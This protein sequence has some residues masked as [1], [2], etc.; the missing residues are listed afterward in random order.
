MGGSDPDFACRGRRRGLPKINSLADFAG[1]DFE[2]K[3]VEDRSNASCSHRATLAGAL[4]Q[5][6]A[7]VHLC[8]VAQRCN[9]KWRKS[10]FPSYEVSAFSFFV[11][12]RTLIG[13]FNNRL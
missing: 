13:D 6:G 10:N 9:Y 8:I 3:V 12:K 11:V 7:Q 5:F 1:K 4:G 2:C